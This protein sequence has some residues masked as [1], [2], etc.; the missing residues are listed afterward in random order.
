MGRNPA[1]GRQGPAHYMA[2]IPTEAQ[3]KRIRVKQIRSTIGRPDTA[4]RTLSALGLHKHQ[5]VVELVNNASVRG[6]LTKVR[7]MVAVSRIDG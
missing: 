1:V 3:A 6:M 7:D 2:T 5:A 4:R